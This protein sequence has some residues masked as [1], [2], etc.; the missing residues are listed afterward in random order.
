ME[1]HVNNDLTAEA[2]L[3]GRQQYAAAHIHAI[4]RPRALLTQAYVAHSHTTFA[5]LKFTN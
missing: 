2:K 4:Y 3:Q 1:I 5:R